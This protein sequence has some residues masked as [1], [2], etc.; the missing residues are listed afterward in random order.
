MLAFFNSF[1]KGLTLFSCFKVVLIGTSWSGENYEESLS[2]SVIS[3]KV[4]SVDDNNT[5][6]CVGF[7]N[8]NRVVV[9]EAFQD[10]KFFV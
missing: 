3:S 8:G 6:A 10:G 9:S 2:R 4:C 5:V 7:H 1:K